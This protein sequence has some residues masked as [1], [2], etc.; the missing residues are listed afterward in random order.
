M[1]A[2]FYKY[3]AL[4]N[5]M[6]VLDPASFE[7]ALTPAVIRLLG[8]RHFGLG[9]DGICYGP[10]PGEFGPPRMRFFN[11]DGSESGKSGN[12]LR[13]FARY[14]WEQ[15]Y[16]EGPS[17]AIGIGGETVQVAL[18]DAGGR[19]MSIE[20]G[21]LSFHSRDIPV[22]GPAREV[23]NE[24]MNVA[25]HTYIITAVTIGNPHC[26]I[27]ADE[28]SE[29]ATRAA[30]PAI[31]V[32][33]HF[34]QRTNVQFGRV[35]DRHTLQIEIWERGAGYTLASGSSSCAAAGAAVKTGRCLSPVE[36][37]MAGGTAQV[38]LEAD[39]RVRLTGA[40]E[41]VGFGVL[42]EDLVARLTGLKD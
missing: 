20:M 24:T 18:T 8:D 29:A 33:P 15:G 42:A 16:V 22:T 39:G 19:R 13:I 1:K 30:G 28:I 9:A 3:Q 27:F 32:D 41:A 7:P 23:I 5:D 10:L 26:V 38:G 34:P 11:P 6:L 36:V 25:G 12:G 37:R 31:E 35:L 17:F 4:G 2:H 40:V 14:L 21:R